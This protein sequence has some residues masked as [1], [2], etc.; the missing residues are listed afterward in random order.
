ME[1]TNPN[2]SSAVPPL[3]FFASVPTTTGGVGGGGRA[4]SSPSSIADP[5]IFDD[6][7]CLMCVATFSFLLG[8]FGGYVLSVLLDSRSRRCPR[9]DD[10]DDRKKGLSTRLY[11]R[12]EEDVEEELDAD[13]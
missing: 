13:G 1:L 11:E 8:A 5:L 12:I 9:C 7:T 2:L 3:V 6:G 10:D 4:G